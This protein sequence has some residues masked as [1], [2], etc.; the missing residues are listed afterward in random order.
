[1]NILFVV[2]V[3]IA[4]GILTNVVSNLIVPKTS[5]EKRLAFSVFIGLVALTLA[6]NIY[7]DPPPIAST[8][9][10]GDVSGN[11][12]PAQFHRALVDT[13]HNFDDTY[14]ALVKVGI[15]G[16]GFEKSGADEFTVNR[17]SQ[18]EV[19]IISFS[20]Y[21]VTE[22]SPMPNL[23]TNAEI[24]SI[25]VF[26]NQGGKVFLIGIGWVWTEYAKRPI[27]EYPLNLITKDY[28]LSFTEGGNYSCG[29]RI[30]QVIIDSEDIYSQHPIARNVRKVASDEAGKVRALPGII[31]VQSPSIP[32]M[33]CSK[34]NPLLAVVQLERGRGKIVAVTH[35]DFVIRN[36]DS[37][38]Y[39]NRQLL[40]NILFWLVES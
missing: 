15:Q 11:P 14:N 21:T 19:L 25:R 1:M 31:S 17:L 5:R 38:T 16:W 18:Y 4:L 12:K 3:G 37:K 32:I 34:T 24:D 26:V 23:F 30:N 22:K 20:S 39:D 2:L 8:A 33:S 35:P 10:I 29:T 7:P 13:R 6:I 28:G 27:D 9:S 40:E 36:L